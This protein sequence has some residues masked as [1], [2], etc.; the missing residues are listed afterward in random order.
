VVGSQ[1][2]VEM[3]MHEG[4]HAMHVFEA[5]HLPYLWQ[6]DV[7]SLGAEFAE[8]GSMAMEFLAA[9]YLTRDEGGFYEKRDAA[10]ARIEHLEQ[11][12]L[13]LWPRMMIYDAFQHWVYEHPDEAMDPAAC[14]T[15]C[16][17]QS[18]RFTPVVD[19]E[20]LED[21]L[22]TAWH[23]VLHIHVV[24]FY[25]IEYALAEL[26]AVQIWANSL[27]DRKEAA[28]RYRHAL[29]LGD[30]RPIPELYAAAGAR[31]AFDRDTL[32]DAVALVE[33]TLEELD[34]QAG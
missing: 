29:S 8:V 7:N 33:R 11:R 13:G 1:N 17:E 2:D 5:G 15:V 26:G 34:R 24:P 25:M 20:G 19:Y 31:F 23:N 16:A 22:A 4:G 21:A 14:D 10:R 32:R 9:P 28:R 6:R 27:R 18:R 3:L 30:T 12:V